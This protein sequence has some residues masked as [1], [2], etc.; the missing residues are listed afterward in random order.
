[1][2]GQA[3]PATIDAC[4]KQAGKQKG[5][6]RVVAA[7]AKCRKGERRLT[8]A[9]AAVPAPGATGPAGPAG[10][11]GPTGP[12]GAK[13]DAGPQGPQGPAGSAET[14][15]SILTKLLAVDGSGSGLDASLLDGFNS[16]YFLPAT[17]KAADADELDGITSSGFA[18]LSA[19]S[20]GL[21]SISGGIAAHSCLDYDVPLGGVDPGNVVIV[22]EGAGVTLPAGVIMTS[23]SVQ[24]GSNVHLRFCN[25]QGAAVPGFTSFPIRWYAFTP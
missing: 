24:S 22:R 8:W 23:G 6:L 13:G 7:Q 16:T 18:R 19:S 11:A 1:V 5:Q 9:S 14:G 4:V 10:P 12:A 25:V 2:T 20:T 17:G 15:S 3:A 21:V